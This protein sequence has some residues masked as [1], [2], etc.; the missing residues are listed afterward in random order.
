M[1]MFG[2]VGVR[3]DL[4]Y[5]HAFQ[6]ITFLGVAISKLKLDFGRA[7]AGLVLQF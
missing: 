4:R 2:H 3:G 1:L 6:D 7:S 5:F